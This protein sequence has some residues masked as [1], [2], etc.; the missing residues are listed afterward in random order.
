MVFPVLHGSFGED[1]TIQGLLETAGIPYVGAG[2]LGSSL[3]MD[4]EKTKQIWKESG[5]PVVPY[6]LSRKED[7][8]KKSEELKRIIRETEKLGFPVFVKPCSVGSS[9]GITKVKARDGLKKALEAAFKFDTKVLIEQGIDAREIECSVLGNRTPQAFTPGEIVSSHEFYDYE[10]KYLDPRGAE[11]LIPARLDGRKQEEIKSLAVKAYEAA[12]V[13]GMARVDFFVD[14]ESGK[15]YLNEI[16]TIPGF[17]NIS[18]FPR[19][20]EHDG[21]KYPELLES[22]IRLGLERHSL[23]QGITY[24]YQ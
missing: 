22:L 15:I 10:A 14:R 3:S 8:L 9:V 13:E 16:N 19:M 5:L 11:L 1:G 12:A 4:K 24:R 17:T 18:M 21:L 6:V 23:R 20:C 7:F 2:V